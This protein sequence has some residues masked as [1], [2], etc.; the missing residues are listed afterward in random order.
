[1]VYSSCYI[2]IANKA[3]N[4]KESEEKTQFILS[5]IYLFTGQA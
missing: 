5:N 3:D 2:L 1:M 4:H